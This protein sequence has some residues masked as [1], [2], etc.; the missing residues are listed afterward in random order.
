MSEMIRSRRRVKKTMRVY[1]RSG[2][3]GGGAVVDG[4]GE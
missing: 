3:S 1:E 2:G 4:G